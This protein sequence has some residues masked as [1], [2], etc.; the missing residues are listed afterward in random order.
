MCVG[1]GG[2]L[3]ALCVFF[4][5]DTI[6]SSFTYYILKEKKSILPLILKQ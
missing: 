3:G 5:V 4:V 1:G 6:V 2:G